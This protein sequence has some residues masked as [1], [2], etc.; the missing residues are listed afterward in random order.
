MII[1]LS[2][3]K[4]HGKSSV[5][6]YLKSKHRFTKISWAEPL[7]EIVGKQLFGLTYEQLYGTQEDKERIIPKWGMSSREILQKVGTECFRKIIHPD[8]W[9]IVGMDYIQKE[10]NIGND[11]VVSDCRFPNEME[12][13]KKLGGITVR[14]V[15]LDKNGDW[16]QETD[17]HDSETALDKYN[18]DYAMS[19]NEGDLKGLYY[20]IDGI[21]NATNRKR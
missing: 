20:Q 1:G 13:I 21:I 3:K 14:V 10:A 11:V 7:K 9:V 8:F 6:R 4:Q 12:A 5:A 15:K 2:G 16:I 18:H 17:E 19:A